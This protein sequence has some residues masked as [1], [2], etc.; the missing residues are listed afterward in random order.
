MA[1]R[2]SEEDRGAHSGCRSDLES[3]SVSSSDVVHPLALF[4]TKSQ[5]RKLIFRTNG[6]PLMSPKECSSV[7]DIVEEYHKNVLGGKWGTVR[8]SSVKTTDVAVEDIPVLRP[9][10]LALLHTKL[11]PL[12]SLAFPILADG[13]TLYDTESKLCRLRVHDAFIVRY[14]A[15]DELSLSLPEHCD[16]SSMSII[17]ALNEEE[18]NNTDQHEDYQECQEQSQYQEGRETHMKYKGGG[19]WFESL[20]VQGQVI[21]ADIGQAVMFAGPLKHA[22]YPITAG[23]RNILVLFLYVEG[24]HYGPYLQDSRSK[25][26][27]LEKKLEC[28]VDTIE[29]KRSSG[30]ERGGFVVYRQTVEL[31]SMLNEVRDS[32][33]FDA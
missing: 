10:L 8:K 29:E 22:G 25:V 28:S 1:H 23:I 9:W 33:N 12:L 16:T 19:T 4:N 3:F 14:D 13:S 30:A 6:D 11:F 7:I 27:F 5:Q 31:V 18:K 2:I 17:F 20:G 32:D 21:N 24:F 26:P 15:V